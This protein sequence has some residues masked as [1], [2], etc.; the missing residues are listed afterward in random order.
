MKF[1]IDVN[2]S[3]TV[4]E[5]LMSL[6]HDAVCVSETDP[7][8]SDSHILDWAVREQRVIITTDKDFEEKIWRERREHCGILRLENLP[9]AERHALLLYVL[10]CHV[11]DLES[12]AIVIALQKKIRIRR[13][14]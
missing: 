4:A 2:T 13:V 8:M 5:W 3:R 12:G 1:L 10:N 6:G 7:R 11:N 14:V 9:R